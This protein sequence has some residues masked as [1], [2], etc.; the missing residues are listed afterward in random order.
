MLFRSNKLQFYLELKYSIAAYLL[1]IVDYIFKIDLVTSTNKIQTVKR[2]KEN[3]SL[4][5][6][7]KTPIINRN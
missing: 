2:S 4:K 5:H 7:N 3:E 1:Q 6:F